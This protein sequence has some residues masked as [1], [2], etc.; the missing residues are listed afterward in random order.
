PKRTSGCG[1]LR[2]PENGITNARR[3]GSRPILQFD[4]AGSLFPLL[5]S[6]RV[7]TQ[8]ILPRTK[9]SPLLRMVVASSLKTLTSSNFSVRS[10][11]TELVPCY[12]IKLSSHLRLFW[13]LR[14]QTSS[15][16]AWGCRHI[17]LNASRS[18]YLVSLGEV[19]G[20]TPYRACTHRPRKASTK[21]GNYPQ[22]TF[23]LGPPPPQV[24]P[25]LD[26]QL[27]TAHKG[28]VDR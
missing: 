18:L 24:H 25:S 1:T 12:A 21:R 26:V 15:T 6:I 9:N 4:C 28:R 10:T 11:P 19:V 8:V 16:M 7:P 13:Q 5:P 2:V 20:R 14:P 27:T 23:R 17:P 22:T 3:Y